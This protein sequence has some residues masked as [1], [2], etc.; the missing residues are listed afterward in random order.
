MNDPDTHAL[1]LVR[2]ALGRYTDASPQEIQMDTALADIQ[3][4]S[5]TLAELLFELEDQLGTT[6]SET[7]T[8][9]VHVSDL[10]TLVSPYLVHDD[11]KS[12]A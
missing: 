4:D 9:P 11:L 2:Q 10:V 3:I 8:L 1:Q 12:R 7:S 6:L 5:L